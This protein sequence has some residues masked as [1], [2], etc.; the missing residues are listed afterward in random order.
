MIRTGFPLRMRI[1]SS[2]NPNLSLDRNDLSS[3][4]IPAWSQFPTCA[5]KRNTFVTQAADSRVCKETQARVR[6][7]AD[8]KTSLQKTFLTC[9]IGCYF[10]L[11]CSIFNPA[12][13][14]A[15]ATDFSSFSLENFATFHS[16]RAVGVTTATRPKRD[17][18][19]SSLS[20]FP[21]SDLS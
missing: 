4:E 18:N 10:F 7:H 3:F 6:P 1:K 16:P 9:D 17:S 13:L 11:A 21:L 8:V 12:K 2:L 20:L 5:K 14:E 19:P 15:P